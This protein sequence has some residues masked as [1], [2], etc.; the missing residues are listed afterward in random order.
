MAA[1]WLLPA[2]CL[3]TTLGP[4]GP[5]AVARAAMTTAGAKALL[6]LPAGSIS[7]GGTSSG[8]LI[9][10]A[11]IPL[12]GP[13][14]AFFPHIA[15]RGMTYGTD[16]MVGFIERIAARVAA[17][18]PGTRT[19]LGNISLRTGGR[20]QWHASHQVGRD[21][22]LAFF[23]IDER[24]RPVV[25]HDYVKMNRRGVSRDGL[26]RFDL[27]RNLSLVLAMLADQDAPVQWVF[28]ARWLE[29]LLLEHAEDEGVDPELR[30]RM[31]ELMRQ[32][33]DSAPHDDHYHVR[34]FCS[35]ED[36]K[37]GCLNREPWRDWVDMHDEQWEE[38]V[39]R[40]G[41]ILDLPEATLRLRAVRLMERIRAVP[42]VPRLVT[43]LSDRD[44]GVRQA[45]LRAIETIGDPIAAPGLLARLRQTDEPAWAGS[46]FEVYETLDHPDLAA[47]A[48]RLI[49]RPAALL[50][51][52]IARHHL[53]PLQVHAA[54]ILGE[55]GR[56]EAVPPLLKLLASPSP[57]VRV[58]AHDALGQVTNLR[59]RGSPASRKAA[60]HRALA[61]KWRGLWSKHRRSSWL[62]L[63]RAGFRSHGIRLRG[64]RYVARDIPRLIS[65]IGHRNPSVSKNA[66]RVLSAITGHS[67]APRSGSRHREVRR[68]VRHWRWWYR[69]HKGRLTLSQ[70]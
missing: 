51:R 15:S 68:L 3:G 47:I 55:R 33:G 16:E 22:D 24:G 63:T 53:S 31:A 18:H 70:R 43:T 30:R 2:L 25:L 35:L 36:R 21:V 11:S 39:D 8:R 28:V 40:L 34:L 6:T 29:A 37:Y 13:H 69:R 44:V 7:M 14:H 17:D 60:R 64:D 58:A 45:A 42:A 20:S 61:R 41:E 56:K 57:A 10:A 65:A 19:R 32:P 54:D 62:K 4:E 48:T 23:V 46:L 49:Q 52:K 66:N 1:L 26:L 38:H 5:D 67:V 50:S 9:R 12:T 27:S 59:V